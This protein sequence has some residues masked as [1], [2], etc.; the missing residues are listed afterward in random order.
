MVTLFSLV[1]IPFH[2]KAIMEVYFVTQNA[3]DLLDEKMKNNIGLKFAYRSTILVEIKKTLTLFG[4]ELE[5]E[6]NQK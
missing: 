1:K 6:S 5:D 4:V 3:D 2:L